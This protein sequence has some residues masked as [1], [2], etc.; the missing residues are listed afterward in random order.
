MIEM[1]LGFWLLYLGSICLYDQATKTG[2]KGP[3]DALVM[4]CV[5]GVS[6]VGDVGVS[7]GCIG[8]GQKWISSEWLGGRKG[9]RIV[10]VD[11]RDVKNVK[12]CFSV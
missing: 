4:M 7:V 11:W 9:N 3:V 6:V 2:H 12:W 5:G 1:E 10:M 8:C